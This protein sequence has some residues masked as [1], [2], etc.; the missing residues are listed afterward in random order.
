MGFFTGLELGELEQGSWKEQAQSP[1]LRAAIEQMQALHRQLAVHLRT[2]N[3]DL[4]L[5][6]PD[7]S[8]TQFGTV[9]DRL[10]ENVLT[11][12]YTRTRN[13]AVTVERLM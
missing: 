4:H 3:L 12:A 9:S 1:V 5:L 7:S 11:V 13:Q 6:T 8:P 10:S 2:Q